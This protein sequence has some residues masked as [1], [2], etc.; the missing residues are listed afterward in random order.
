ML[1][2]GGRRKTCSVCDRPEST[3]LCSILP[4]VQLDTNADILILQHPKEAR[5]KMSSV[6]LL[7][8]CLRHCHVVVGEVFEPGIDATIDQHIFNASG[9]T[10]LVF[11]GPAATT[12]LR[13]GRTTD[14]KFNHAFGTTDDHDRPTLVFFDGTWAEARRMMRK[15]Q[16]TLQP[17]F[18]S[19]RIFQ[20]ALDD[21]EQES[22]YRDLRKEP[23][24]GYLST[25]EAVTEVLVRIDRSA[26]GAQAYD[27]CRYVFDR[28]V[29][30]QE[31][32]HQA[33]KLAS[34]QYWVKTDL[35]A[36]S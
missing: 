4:P 27:T 6:P 36:P 15:N 23:K 5:R 29:A 12:I 7:S 26:L 17:L 25:L 24:A 13:D 3:C 11:P 1:S 21:V 10:Y 18:D 34:T 30:Q 35:Q 16:P 32:F 8:R 20:M 9:Q 31:I 19:G 2:T 33:G 14:P 28:M 22:L